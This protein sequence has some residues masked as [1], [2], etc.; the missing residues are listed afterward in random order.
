VELSDEEEDQQK[1]KC[2]VAV[3]TAGGGYRGQPAL[4]KSKILN[5]VLADHGGKHRALEARFVINAS[6]LPCGDTATA[7]VGTHVAKVKA[8]GMSEDLKF[9]GSHVKEFIDKYVDR[10]R[11]NLVFLDEKGDNQSVTLA[12]I[13]TRWLRECGHKIQHTT[14]VD[15][16]S[17]RCSGNCSTCVKDEGSP[18]RIEANRVIA[19]LRVWCPFLEDKHDDA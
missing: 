19:N 7:H 4:E 13:I 17:W 10:P 16:A 3:F 2:M 14:H 12:F 6:H 5:N 1:K 15:Q 9:I 11:V 8:L 18:A